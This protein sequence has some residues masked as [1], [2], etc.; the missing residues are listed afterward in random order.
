MA[1]SRDAPS[2]YPYMDEHSGIQLATTADDRA[3][4]RGLEGP[5]SSGAQHLLGVVVPVGPDHLIM[6]AGCP[7]LAAQ[8][9]SEGLQVD[10]LEVDGYVH[11][12]GALGCLTA[13]LR[14]EVPKSR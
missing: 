8:F 4:D 13:V 14:R 2:R 10:E 9:P 12:A 1:R 11:A 3:R 5:V 6:P 7:Q